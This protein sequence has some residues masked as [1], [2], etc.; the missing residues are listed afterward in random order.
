M[1][2]PVEPIDVPVR[3]R[4]GCRDLGLRTLAL[5]IWRA[6]LAWPP[7]PS[8]LRLT[9]IDHILERGNAA[10]TGIV[11]A[12]DIPQGFD[13]DDPYD[14]VTVYWGTADKRPHRTTEA[15]GSLTLATHDWDD[16]LQVRYE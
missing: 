7:I 11:T 4:T 5:S 14:L 16:A 13:P 12:D 10:P 9:V 6:P 1:T 2:E 3:R 8:E 15:A